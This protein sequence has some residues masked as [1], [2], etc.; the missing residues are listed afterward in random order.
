MTLPN[1]LLALAL[2]VPGVGTERP[3]P[4]PPGPR[5]GRATVRVVATL[6]V[7]GEIAAV[8]GGDAVEVASIADPREDAH[9]VR[10]KPSFALLIRRADVFITTGLDLE[11][12]VPALLDKAGNSN[13]AEGGPGY[14]TTH[15]GIEL[16]DVPTTADRA[17]GDI[18]I[19]GNPHIVTDPLN[20]I[21]VARNIATGLS[22]ALPA[23]A[24]RFQRNLDGFIDRIH[25]RMYGD[26]LVEMLGG[27]TLARLDAQGR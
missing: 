13:V 8:I 6:P 9:F 26:R 25:R 18:H 12:W 14:V 17:G 10:P 4:A 16:L 23:E 19:Y 22:R 5:D 3:A 27:E 24:E 11:L 21:Q 15:S 20:V 2:A 7:Y 1:A